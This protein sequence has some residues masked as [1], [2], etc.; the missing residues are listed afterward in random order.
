MK[1]LVTLLAALAALQTYAQRIEATLPSPDA[2]SLGMGGV[3]MTTLSGS[4]AIYNNSATAIFSH[5]PSQVSSSYY[6]QRSF[7]YYAVSGFCRFDNINLVQAGWRQFL[8]E[9]GNNDMAV[10]LGYARRIGD[11]WAVGIVLSAAWSMPLEN[12]GSYSTL[13][14]G[15]K[16]GN[17]GGYLRDTEYTLPMDFTVGAALDTFL[18]DAHEITVGTDLGYYFSPSAVRGFQM[19]LGA[20]YNLMQLVQLRT[21]YHYGERRDYY[22]SYWTVGAG[23]RILH[24]RLDFAYLF[25]KKHSLLRNTYSISFG[26]DF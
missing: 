7:D 21:G 5:T 4:H 2:K 9:H 24:L 1:R 25:A 14:A 20:E 23:L 17:L 13:R 19:S 10:D 26:L 22:P 15:A 11:R 3:M 6:G 18:T 16:L 12:V 8:R